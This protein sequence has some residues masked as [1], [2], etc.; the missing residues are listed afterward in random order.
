MRTAFLIDGFNLYHSIKDVIRDGHGGPTLKWLN[1]PGLCASI[2][3]DCGEMPREAYVSEVHYFSALAR[4]MEPRNP[5]IVKRHETLIEALKNADVTV[6]LAAFKKTAKGHEE[7]ETDVAIA[8][9]LLELFHTDAADCAFIMSGDTDLMPAVR[10][11]RRMYPGRRVCFAFPYKRQNN[12][13][14]DAADV[15]FR[16][17]AHRYVKHVFPDPLVR[18]DGTEIHCPQKWREEQASKPT[19]G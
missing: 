2:I 1:I 15:H 16:I 13:L 14:K 9:T 19:A 8:V 6:H 11:V 17:R 3:R 18:G 7:K 10:A 5:G 4:H 12:I